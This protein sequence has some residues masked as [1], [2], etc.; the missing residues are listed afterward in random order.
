MNNETQ[1][2]QI[3]NRLI[4]IS[5]KDLSPGAQNAQSLHAIS[6]F[7]LDH[8]AVFKAWNNQYVVSLSVLD[9]NHLGNLLAKIE[10]HGIP[11]SAFYEPDLNFELTAICLEATEKASKLV[12]SLPLAFKEHT[13]KES[14]KV[15]MNNI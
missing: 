14:S 1:L 15:L 3:C 7:A 9:E 8:P 5:R 4:I 13:K 11:A 12:S 6:Q 10:S 2:G